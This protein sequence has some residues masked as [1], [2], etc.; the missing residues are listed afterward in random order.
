M[1]KRWDRGKD[2]LLRMLLDS[3]RRMDMTPDAQ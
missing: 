3:Q 1:S 2:R